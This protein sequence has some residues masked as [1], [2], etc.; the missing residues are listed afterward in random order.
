MVDL[1]NS[2]RGICLTGKLASID[3]EQLTWGGRVLA[4]GPGAE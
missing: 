3:Q 4:E 2:T 1:C